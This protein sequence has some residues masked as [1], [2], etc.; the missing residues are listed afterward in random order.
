MTTFATEDLLVQ[1]QGS[2]IRLIPAD[3][4]TRDKYQ[5]PTLRE[6]F[7][8][9]VN[10]YVMNSLSQYQYLNEQTAESCGF[11]SADNALGS[12]IRKVAKARSAE[13]IIHNDRQVMR[14]G[15]SLIKYESYTANNDEELAGI[16]FK[17]PLLHEQKI[18]GVFGCTIISNDNLQLA[19]SLDQLAK[20]GILWHAES[21]NAMK[22]SGMQIHGIH[23]NRHEISIMRQLIFGYTVK[24]IG[25]QIGLSHRTVEHY[26][27]KIRLKT[28][29][30]SR[31]ELI[32][33]FIDHVI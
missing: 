3:D 23:F 5:L 20:A 12:T 24:E 26:L 29:L 2:G 10:I 32:R 14:S 22:N 31:P 9:P 18:H 33:F 1:R 19:K 17:F 15:Q 28:S 4:K 21:D 13:A 8:L 27:E 7:S 25:R 16:S 6:I 11:I 30:N